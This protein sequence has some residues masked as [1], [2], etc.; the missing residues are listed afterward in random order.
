MSNCG[1]CKSPFVKGGF[2]GNV[3]IAP[4]GAHKRPAG[5]SP[6]FRSKIKRIAPRAI[7]FVFCI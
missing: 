4:T 2:R 7:L 3:K 6:V 5:S 1:P